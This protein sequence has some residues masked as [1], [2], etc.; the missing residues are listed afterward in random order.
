MHE[1]H[2]GSL[3][4]AAQSSDLIE[5]GI[6]QTQPQVIWPAAESN[7]VG[8]DCLQGSQS[9]FRVSAAAVATH[10]MTPLVVTPGGTS[11]TVTRASISWCGTCCCL[12]AAAATW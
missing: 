3:P 7:I 1:E 11:P 2:V 4:V 5:V 9:L 12:S 10:R 8:N 6:S